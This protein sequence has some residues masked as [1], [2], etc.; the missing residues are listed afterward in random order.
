MSFHQN[1]SRR[2]GHL[3]PAQYSQDQG[4]HLRRQSSFENGDDTPPFDASANLHQG[5]SSTRTPS[6]TPGDAYD[7]PAQNIY[8]PSSRGTYGPSSPS[9]LSGYQHQYQSTPS[10]TPVSYNPQQFARTQSQS[11]PAVYQSNANAYT[12]GSGNIAP[13]NPALYQHPSTQFAQLPYSQSYTSPIVA[14]SH[15]HWAPQSSFDEI[16]APSQ[17]VPP[18]A[19]PPKPTAYLPPPHAAP[20]APNGSSY[21]TADGPPSQQARMSQSVR[22]SAAAEVPHPTM[23][24]PPSQ[25]SEGG[26]TS[27]GALQRHPTSRPLPSAPLE[28]DPSEEG[29]DDDDTLQSEAEL[30]Q[31]RLF[32]YI[33][34]NLQ[35]SGSGAPSNWRFGDVVGD[36]LHRYDSTATTL[37]PVSNMYDDDSDPEAAAGL[38]A[39]EIA[40]QQDSSRESGELF[41]SQEETNSSVAMP[42]YTDA[43]SDSD[44]AY[45]N[46]DLGLYSGGYDA[47]VSYGGIDLT[48]SYEHSGEMDDHS[49]PLPTIHDI[50]RSEDR[51]SSLG[52]GGSAQL[53]TGRNRAYS[54]DNGDEQSGLSGKSGSLIKDGFTP[55]YYGPGPS[56][57]GE[58][59]LPDLPSDAQPSS[60]NNTPLVSRSDGRNRDSQHAWHN[61]FIQSYQDPN[62][63]ETT[64]AHQPQAMPRSASYI[65]SSNH[66]RATFPTRAKT[67]AEEEKAAKHRMSRQMQL[68]RAIGSLDG[69]DSGPSVPHDL[70]TLPGGRRKKFNPNKL[71][72]GD[73]EK[74]LEPWA[75]SSIA[76][77][78]REMCGGETDSVDSDLREMTLRDGLVRLFTHKVPTMNETD[79]ETL[80]E[81]VIKG[82]FDAGLLIRDEEWVKLGIGEISGV[83]WQLTGS[84]C[85]SSIH[86]HEGTGRCYAWF[87]SRTL[88]KITQQQP[89]EVRLNREG[90]DAFYKITAKDLEGKSKK[91]IERQHNLHEIVTGEHQ[92]LADIDILTKYYRDALASSQPSKIPPAKLPKFLQV[93]FGNID[94]VKKVNED[95]LLPQLK[96][97]QKMEGPWVSGYASIFREWIR[98]ARGPYIK[99][100]AALPHAT[101]QHRREQHN[102]LLFSE[103]LDATQRIPETRRLGIDSFLKGPTTRL[104][105]Y[106]FLLEPV[107]SKMLE[108]SE[109]KATLVKA[110]EEIKAVVVECDRVLGEQKAIAEVQSLKHS[111][112]MRGTDYRVDLCLQ[113]KHRKLLHKGDLLRRGNNGLSWISSRAFLLDNFFVLGKYVGG[114]EGFER[115]DV[116]KPPIPMRLLVL[117]SAKDNPV[118]KKEGLVGVASTSVRSTTPAVADAKPS[119]NHTNIGS[120]IDNKNSVV[121]KT[122]VISNSES[123]AKSQYLYPMRIKHLGKPES[124]VVYASKAQDRNQWSK[125]IVRAKTQ[126]AASL[127]EQNAE[128]FSMRVIADSAFAYDVPMDC[129][130]V[131]EGTPLYRAI[132][133]FEDTRGASRPSPVCKFRV[134]CATNFTAFGKS[135]LAVGTEDALYISE[136]SNGN[137]HEWHKSIDQPHVTQ[138]AVLEEFSMFLII[139]GKAL[140]AY[141][142]DTIVSPSNF[143]AP[144][145]ARRSP[146]RLASNV[147]HFVT[148]RMKDRFLIIYKKKEGANSVFKVVEPIFQK[149]TEKKA[150]LFGRRGLLGGGVTEFF[151]DFDEFYVPTESFG[152][153]TFNKTIAISTARGFELLTLDEKTPSTIPGN[154]HDPAWPEFGPKLQGFLNR[155]RGM[156]RLDEHEFICVYE[157]ACVYIDSNGNL[158][159]SECYFKL[160]GKAKSATKFKNYLVVFHDDFVE[161]RDVR[162]GRSRQII[163]GRDIRCLDPGD[164]GRDGA[165]RNVKFAMTHPEHP[166]VQLLVELNLKED[167][168]SEWQG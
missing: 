9:T 58:R 94:E 30:Q 135:I 35:H 102:N 138:I 108:D 153:N 100:A 97:K 49:R 29:W 56:E 121:P 137:P 5:E 45:A 130:A 156:F 43:S 104:Q 1:G 52:S 144:P 70:P 78:L 74:C 73:Y 19:L 4:L 24:N 93:L 87:C 167:V 68:S 132:R 66:P 8:G 101:V 141:H 134:N 55:Y 61:E 11:H 40:D 107:L 2:Y 59:P 47:Q 23:P 84:G 142:L 163:E 114:P 122:N 38:Q 44:Y 115:Y 99:Y 67:D 128:P 147:A 6:T 90:W 10:H 26:F 113:E 75:L 164:M 82:M 81:H 41:D 140:I 112:Q 143:A 22:T 159:R 95:Y 149:A 27:P 109:E 72:S 31:E 146:Q 155:P 91:E 16:Y 117:E 17:A 158:N 69:Y 76:A 125:I 148:C 98:K 25:Y 36:G 80:S 51:D 103:F 111:L 123:E 168:T 110:I 136:V 21:Y 106:P 166:R 54:Y 60:Y 92:Y 13:Y 32:Q 127:H 12:S 154:S 152:L 57:G 161:I 151:R 116:S 96:Y 42:A 131:I 126:Y 46:M 53:Q 124:Y 85:Y 64:T 165:H 150:K 48:P 86:K 145:N 33:N 18:V 129:P 139:T 7:D 79:A 162:S 105:R 157:E 133:K 14:Q 65:G 62:A 50:H 3:P 15:S 119:L 160:D 89:F 28:E 88:K 118:V 20:Y 34:S 39:M 37:R 120:P 83:L 77:W 71:S 63:Y